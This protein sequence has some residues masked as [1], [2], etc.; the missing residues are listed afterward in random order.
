MVPNVT[1]TYDVALERE[2][3]ESLMVGV[4]PQFG[5][6]TFREFTLAPVGV[7]ASDRARSRRLGAAVHARPARVQRRRRGARQAETT[8][9]WAKFLEAATRIRTCCRCTPR[10]P[11]FYLE[12]KQPKEALGSRRSGSSRASRATRA[13]CAWLRGVQRQARQPGRSRQGAQGA[14]VAEGRGR[15]D[16]AL[17]RGRR[18]AQAGRSRQRAEAASRKRWWRSPELHQATEALMLVYARKGDWARRRRRPSR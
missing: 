1:F 11:P 10:S 3:Y 9:R 17:Q 16:P 7:A 6:T 4:K 18:G 2:G 12:K 13:G 8:P 14:A 5:E 15:C